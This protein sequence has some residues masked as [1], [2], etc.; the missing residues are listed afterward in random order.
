[1]STDILLFYRNDSTQ[2][3]EFFTKCQACK[4][5]WLPGPRSSLSS[6]G[7]VSVTTR[8]TSTQAHVCDLTTWKRLWCRSDVARGE[9]LWFTGNANSTFLCRLS[10]AEQITTR[11]LDR[12]CEQTLRL[13]FPP[14]SL[15][16]KKRCWGECPYPLIASKPPHRQDTVNTICKHKSALCR[17]VCSTVT[18]YWCAFVTETR[19]TYNSFTSQH[20]RNISGLNL[21]LLDWTVC[22]IG[23]ATGNDPAAVHNKKKAL[24]WKQTLNDCMKSDTDTALLLPVYIRA[25]SGGSDYVQWK[26]TMKRVAHRQWDKTEPSLPWVNNQTLTTHW[27][28]ARTQLWTRFSLCSAFISLPYTAF[29]FFFFLNPTHPLLHTAQSSKNKNQ[30]PKNYSTLKIVSKQTSLTCSKYR[31]KLLL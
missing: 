17:F 1:M 28:H 11:E 6:C 2:T 18:V 21:L 30:T 3:Q 27:L 12:R 4:F 20:C 9:K 16:T 19:V 23:T 8:H 25:K 7:Q 29:F 22:H 13:F 10:A 5:N 24:P 26:F 31:I 14:K 15:K